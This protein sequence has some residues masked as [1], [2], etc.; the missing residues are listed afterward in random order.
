MAGRIRISPDQVRGVASQFRGKSQESGTMAQQLTSAVNGMQA[1]W[2]GMAAQKFY[3]DFTQW[4]QQMTKYVDLLNGIASQLDS[5]A[6]T[7]EQTD[8]QLAGR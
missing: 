4:Q 2:E 6:N 5:I 8:Q 7:I 3:S 1:E